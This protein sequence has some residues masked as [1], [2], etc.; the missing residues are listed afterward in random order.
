VVWVRVLH[1]DPALERGWIV[2]PQIVVRVAREAVTTRHLA[3]AIRI[4]G[5]AERHRPAVEL[6]QEVFGVKLVIFDA[7]PLVDRDAEALGHPRRRH[8][9]LDRVLAPLHRHVLSS[10]DNRKARGSLS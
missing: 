8:P 7:A 5:P 3:A 4:H 6:V 10:H 2:Q 1:V 9:R